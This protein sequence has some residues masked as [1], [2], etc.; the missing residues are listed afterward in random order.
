[1]LYSPDVVFQ[2]YKEA[3][4]ASYFWIDDVFV[5]GI[6]AARANI[7][8]SSMGDLVLSE[9]RVADLRSKETS[10]D[11][12]IFGPPNLSIADIYWFWETVSAWGDRIPSLSAN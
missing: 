6:M 9:Q 5:T 8:R 3:Q 4:S 10:E 2:L 1:M 12:F 7:G 11:F